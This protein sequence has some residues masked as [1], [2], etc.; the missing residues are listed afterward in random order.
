MK[1]SPFTKV[2]HI[3][4]VVKDLDQAIAHYR[5]LGIGTLGPP[6]VYPEEPVISE[7]TNEARPG[8]AQIMSKTLELDGIKLELI[9][10]IGNSSSGMA[11]KFLQD[12]GEGINHMGFLVGDIDNETDK[13]VEK[14]F[15]VIMAIR[16]QRGGGCSYFDTGKIGGVL[17]ELVQ[18][19]PKRGNQ[20]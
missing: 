8:T 2:H 5:S 9:Q 18:P 12:R 6:L 15:R 11:S 10:P 19:P 14:G 13:L 20:P 1:N 3:G 4:I 17:F 7:G 16:Y